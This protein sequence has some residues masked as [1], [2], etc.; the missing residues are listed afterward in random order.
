[1]ISLKN[2]ITGGSMKKNQYEMFF[3]SIFI[4]SVINSL[5]F[6]AQNDSSMVIGNFF[7]SL[8]SILFYKTFTDDYR[9][10]E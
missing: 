6:V 10:N 7:F 3:I 8:G 5:F 1:M 2:L 4:A 9:N